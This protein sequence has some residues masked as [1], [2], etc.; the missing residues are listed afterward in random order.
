MWEFYGNC[1]NCLFILNKIKFLCKLLKNSEN[2]L[3]TFMQIVIMF[4]R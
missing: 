2:I 4:T 1:E 3:K